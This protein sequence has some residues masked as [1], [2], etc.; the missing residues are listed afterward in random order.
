MRDLR[1][2][3]KL[4]DRHTELRVYG[5]N[6]GATEGMFRI[7]WQREIGA[8]VWL[9][10]IASAGKGWEH[11]SVSTQNRT[12]TWA[13]MEHIKRLFFNDDETVMQLHV[14]PSEHVNRH[15]YCLHLWRPIGVE[16][17][18]PPAIFVGPASR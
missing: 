5:E 2:L 3:D 7:L 10:V 1:A 17:P 13:E 11:V 18:R 15:E 9:T 4:R 6:G 8:P 12:P 16:I 14:P